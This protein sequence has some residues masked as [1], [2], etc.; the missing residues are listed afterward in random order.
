ML[1]FTTYGGV[2]LVICLAPQNSRTSVGL[3]RK[4]TLAATEGRVEVTFVESWHDHPGLIAA[5][6]EKLSP[7][8]RPNVPVLFTSHSVPCRTIA[9]QDADAY[10]NQCK[11]TAALV[12]QRCGGDRL[13]QI[14]VEALTLAFVVLGRKSGRRQRH[15][16]LD[17]AVG[18][19]VVE[20]VG[21]RSVDAG[22]CDDGSQTQ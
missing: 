12:A 8:L 15:A 10:S 9:G 17:H 7:T 1:Y 13:A 11:H 20:D 14:D 22:Q 3:Y 18:L 4:A 21:L 19:D 5:F 6:A 16:A 2:D